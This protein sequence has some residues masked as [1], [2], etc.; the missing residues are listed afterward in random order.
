[1]KPPIKLYCDNKATINIYLNLVQHN[2]TKHV[3]V[4]RHF[5]KEKIENGIICLTYIPTKEHTV[6][7]FTKG[8]LQ[9]SFNDLQVGHD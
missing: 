2:W 6:D 7:F 4:E 3:E 9:Q 1:M 5:I 8:L